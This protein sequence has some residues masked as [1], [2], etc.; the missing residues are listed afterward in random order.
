LIKVFLFGYDALWCQK[1]TIN[2]SMNDP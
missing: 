1:K 2:I